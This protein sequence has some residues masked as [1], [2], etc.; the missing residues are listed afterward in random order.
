MINWLTRRDK[1]IP[2]PTVVFDSVGDVLDRIQGGYYSPT[3]EAPKEWREAFPNEATLLDAG[4]L[5][6]PSGEYSF[7]NGL[8]FVDVDQADSIAAT[9]AHEWRHHWQVFNQPTSPGRPIN[10]ELDYRSS[11]TEFFLS[12]A[13]EADAL[14]YELKL[15]PSDC[16]RQWASWLGW[17]EP[18]R[19]YL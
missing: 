6:F 10:P 18:E 9:V 3:Y 1:D 7:R 14:R 8:I 19:V 5:V 4:I 16:A 17:Y 15:A 13:H 12:N 2:R 11:I